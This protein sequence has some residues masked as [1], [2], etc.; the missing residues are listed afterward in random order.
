MSGVYEKVLLRS[1]RIPTR[2]ISTNI[3][4]RK[5][6]TSGLF[7]WIRAPWPTLQGARI[8]EKRQ[9]KTNTVDS[10]R[11]HTT[12]SICRCAQQKRY[13]CISRPQLDNDVS[14]GYEMR[15]AFSRYCHAVAS[16]PL[17]EPDDNIL[18]Q[19]FLFLYIALLWTSKPQCFLTLRRSH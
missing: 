4:C 6:L 19:V 9:N 15:V 18:M 8:H 10:A 7:S 2:K 5:S 1:C 11:L 12:A 3:I 17:Q 13:H 16:G 14:D